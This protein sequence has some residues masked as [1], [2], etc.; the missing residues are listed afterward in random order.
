MFKL[1]TQLIIKYYFKSP[2]FNTSHSNTVNFILCMT[3]FYFITSTFHVYS[4]FMIIFYYLVFSKAQTINSFLHFYSERIN[5]FS[6]LFSNK[7]FYSLYICLQIMFMLYVQ[8]PEEHWEKIKN[9]FMYSIRCQYKGSTCFVKKK[10][11]LPSKES[12][13]RKKL[14]FWENF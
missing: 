5:F 14:R 10:N 8:M 12:R 13:R 2:S 11:C 9:I 7:Y 3:N 1:S 4:R 6:F